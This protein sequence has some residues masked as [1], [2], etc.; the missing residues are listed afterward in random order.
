ME[1]QK[2]ESSSCVEDVTFSWPYNANTVVL[3]AQFLDSWK[4]G[5][6]L[7]EGS[8]PFTFIILIYEWMESLV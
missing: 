4:Q 5:L 6:N 2:S 7:K 1:S 8:L 3:Q